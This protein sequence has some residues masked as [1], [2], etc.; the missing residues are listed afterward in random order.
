M[1][2]LTV[3]AALIAGL[4][5]LAA[6]LVAIRAPTSAQAAGRTVVSLTFDDG[7][8]E[9]YAARAILAERGLNATFFVNSAR[10]GTLGFMSMDQLRDLQADG[11]EIGGHTL[12]HARLTDLP[13]ADQRIE[14]CDDRRALVAAGFDVTSFAYPFGAA[15]PSATAIAAACGYTSARDIGGLVSETCLSCPRAESLPPRNRFLTR[16]AASVKPTTTLD[17]LKGYVTDAQANGG[18]WVQIV[19]HHICDACADNAM[20]KQLLAEFADWLVAQR[21]NGV[22]VRTVA[23]AILAAPG[24]PAQ[25]GPN[26]L[27]NPSLEQDDD[28][29]GSADCFTHIARGQNTGTAG[30]T[31]AAHTGTAAEAINVD[32]YVDG[33]HKFVSTPDAGR[34]APVAA[35]GAHY[36][37][38][39]WYRATGTPRFVA[40]YRTP[41]GRWAW[42]SQSAR[43]ET[44]DG[45]TQATWTTPAMPLEGTH[46]AV[47]LELPARGSLV[48]DDVSLSVV[49]AP[50]AEIA[51]TPIASVTP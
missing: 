38:S 46:I 27:A 42:W 45:W 2:P 3:T 39:A 33:A 11:N 35:P 48:I 30:R 23:D 29:D 4:L 9:Q 43:L 31:T 41:A 20:S 1:R 26:L 18:G 32:E 51:P 12:H 16:A 6:L 44:V 10:I 13:A 5:A 8:D 14:I 28:N 34:C 21:D 22:E 19:M 7:I 50:A 15:D 40:Y 25:N 17:T 24:Q 47:G 49:A 37:V 36:E